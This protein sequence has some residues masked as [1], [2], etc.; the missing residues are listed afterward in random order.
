M[1]KLA[2]G[3][4]TMNA[5]DGVPGSIL[6]QS[7]QSKWREADYT[8]VVDGDL[9][10]SAKVFY[11]TIPNIR[12]VSRPWTGRHVEQYYARNEAVDMGDWLLAMDCDEFPSSQLF[13][14]G[15]FLSKDT[16]KHNANIC[17]SPSIT[18]VAVDRAGPFWRVQDKPNREDW[19]RRSKRL[20]YKR[21]ETNYFITSP[22]GKH[23]TPTQ[24]D[25]KV[26]QQV[27]R[28]IGREDFIHY[29]M[30]TLESFILN[31]CLYVIA[32]PDH[33]GGPQARQLTQEQEDEL[34]R[35]V[36]TYGLDKMSNKEF[37]DLT[38]ERKWPDDFR[39]FVFQFKDH[40]GQSMSKFYYL[41]EYLQK[42]NIDVDKL[43]ACISLGFIPVY[44]KT[45]RSMKIPEDQMLI[46]RTPSIWL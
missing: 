9:T 27:E 2:L 43:M 8:V 42:G 41:Y 16:D 12:V 13:S 40:L 25:K 37:I 6:K 26:M 38:M 22:C 45:K 32:N 31:E 10:P 4:I 35:L 7:L 17:Y 15:H 18:Y 36:R 20:L 1:S 33:E 46:P 21:D 3:Y 34:V 14:V 19:M 44:E 29:H 23:V 28:P 39:D 5:G 30:K 24:V 11:N